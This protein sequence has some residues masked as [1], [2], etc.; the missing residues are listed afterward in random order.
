MQ[1]FIQ[2]LKERKNYI[3]Y[4]YKNKLKKSYKNFK[5][6][7][8]YY[9]LF[10]YFFN[11]YNIILYYKN[12]KKKIYNFFFFFSFIAIFK[13]ILLYKKIYNVLFN[14]QFLLK[15]SKLLKI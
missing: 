13:K 4:L 1:I 3:I 7:I 6:K 14:N 5:K 8:I 2:K 12:L 11:N 9:S 10:L 15:L